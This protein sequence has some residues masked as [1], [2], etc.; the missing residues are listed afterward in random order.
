M[1]KFEKIKLGVQE[2][3]NDYRIFNVKQEDGTYRSFE[4]FLDIAAAIIEGDS[5][6]LNRD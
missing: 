6:K 3:P 4:E 1:L 2:P 5:E